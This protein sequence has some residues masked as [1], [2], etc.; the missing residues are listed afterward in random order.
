MWEHG[1]SSDS[2]EMS[3]PWQRTLGGY[4]LLERLAV[5]GMAEV[6]LARDSVGT[7]V[8]IKRALPRVMQDPMLKAMFVDEVRIAS[9]LHH[10]NLPCVIEGRASEGYYVMEYL[11]GVDVRDVLIDRKAAIPLEHALTIAVVAAEALDAAFHARDRDGS[12]LKV[13]H[14]DISPSNL[15]LGFD[16]RVCV[17]DF[18]VARAD[19]VGR[20]G[21][22]MGVIKGKLTYMAPEQI[23]GTT[24]H[25]SDVFALGVVLFEM[26]LGRKLFVAGPG[27]QAESLDDRQ[28]V[29]PSLVDPHYPLALEAIV[30]RALHADP[31]KR[32]H[33]TR[34]LALALR[35][36]AV[37]SGVRIDP[38]A[39]GAFARAFARARTSEEDYAEIEVDDY[40]D[41][42]RGTSSHASFDPS[43]LIG[44]EETTLVDATPGHLRD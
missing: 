18:G 10:P 43:L 23:R 20:V 7:Q 27:G 13:V 34:E 8:V 29:A 16:G 11:R 30:L 17:L 3:L 5:G 32:F 39:L 1:S 31:E 38:L 24:D 28:V 4:E 33:S 42:A 37:A 44:D 25:R 9:A 26:T 15:F 22:A 12:P 41:V 19:L 6:F 21:T 2:W 36:F 14:R 35:Q 40:V